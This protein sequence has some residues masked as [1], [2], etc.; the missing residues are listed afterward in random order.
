MFVKFTWGSDV[1]PGNIYDDITYLVE[2]LT[3]LSYVICKVEKSTKIP[4][5]YLHR[6]KAD[7]LTKNYKHLLKSAHGGGLAGKDS[8]IAFE[9]VPGGSL[10][11][12]SLIRE[13]RPVLQEPTVDSMHSPYCIECVFLRPCPPHLSASL[14]LQ[15]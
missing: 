2:A 12:Q 10:V 3:L 4:S 8:L 9:H 13:P 15:L 6:R 14:L 5:F 7:P 1:S 11:N